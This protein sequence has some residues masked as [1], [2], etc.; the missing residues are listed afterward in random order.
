MKKRVASFIMAATALV[1]S[2]AGAS[3]AQLGCRSVGF[4]NDR[5][6]INV[7]QDAGKFKTIQL[8]VSGNDIEMRDLKIVYGNG[9]VDDVPVRSVIRA[10]Q[11]TR[12]I[13]L[14][15]TQRFIREVVMTYA[16]RPS[17]KGQAQVCVV[18]R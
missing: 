11:T 12:W 17:F 18:A 9:Q 14:K 16:S 10:G 1:G 6:V 3:A 8:R 13:D 15:G 7:G 4:I 2:V 5:D